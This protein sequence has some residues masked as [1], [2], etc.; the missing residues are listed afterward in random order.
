MLGGG[1][2]GFYLFDETLGQL[3]RVAAYGLADDA[4]SVELDPP[5]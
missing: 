5:R 1:V 2:A 4:G 3:R